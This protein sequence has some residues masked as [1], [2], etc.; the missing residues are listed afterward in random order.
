MGC[1]GPLGPVGPDGRLAGTRNAAKREGRSAAGRAGLTVAADTGRCRSG[2]GQTV[3]G[4]VR[5]VA[6]PAPEKA[7][8]L[9]DLRTGD[10][11]GEVRLPGEVFSQPLRVDILHRYVPL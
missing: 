8:P 6:K 4:A 1:G 9:R 11:V 2:E 5:R 7:V 3:T 10:K